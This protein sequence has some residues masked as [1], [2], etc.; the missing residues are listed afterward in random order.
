MLTTIPT[1]NYGDTLE[2]HRLVAIPGEYDDYGNQRY[3]ETVTSHSGLAI[4]PESATE[5]N[6]NV[7]R[8]N[9]VYLVALPLGIA[10]DAI[11]WVMWRGERW[12]VQGEAER[13]SHPMA[14]T[15]FT[16]IRIARVEG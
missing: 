4:W 13:Y 8:T 12:E 9:T 11:D 1:W 6:Q 2:F 5:F 16:T 10:T 3:D 15:V 7:D 14:G